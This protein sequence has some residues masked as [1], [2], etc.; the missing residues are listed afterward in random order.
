[1]KNKGLQLNTIFS[2][3]GMPIASITTTHRNVG[4]LSSPRSR[5]CWQVNKKRKSRTF[6]PSW[7]NPP[8][9]SRACLQA[10][11]LLLLT[12]TDKNPS[13]AK[14]RIAVPGNKPY[15]KD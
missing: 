10:S 13:R 4:Y 2:G 8:G 15:L 6:F 5:L 9:P 14:L 1:M 3:F 11:D 7:T 12:P